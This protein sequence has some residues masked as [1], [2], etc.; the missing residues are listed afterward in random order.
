M[1]LVPGGAAKRAMLPVDPTQRPVRRRNASRIIVR[2][3]GRVLLVADSDPGKPGSRWY[4]TPGGG[5]DTGET[6]RQAAVRELA[7]ETGL[8]VAPGELLG[9]I[10]H[11]VVTHGYSDQVLVQYEDFYALDLDAPF[12]PDTSGF[13]PDEKITLGE[14]VWADAGQTTRMVV[15]PAEIAD[16][17]VADGSSDIDLG[18]PEESTVPVEYCS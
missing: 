13:T 17:M 3:G 10:A 15:W 1:A 2:S 8:H 6:S 4:V 18:H 11:R 14:F 7:E 5:W 12:I 9:P 16:L